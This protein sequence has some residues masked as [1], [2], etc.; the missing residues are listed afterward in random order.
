MKLELASD[1]VSFLDDFV[2]TQTQE[3]RAYFWEI[4][5]KEVQVFQ[6]VFVDHLLCAFYSDE[7]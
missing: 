7:F 4:Y 6:A 1:M 3:C 5:N 2:L